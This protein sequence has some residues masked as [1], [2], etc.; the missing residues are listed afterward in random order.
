[1]YDRG[2]GVAQS[3]GAAIGWYTRAAEKGF[4]SAQFNLGLKYDIGRGTPEDDARAG[5]WYARA[6]E[7]GHV[8]SEYNLSVLDADK[9]ASVR[10]DDRF[11]E[12]WRELEAEEKYKN[13]AFKPDFQ[14]LVIRQGRASDRDMAQWY[15]IKREEEDRALKLVLAEKYVERSPILG[16]N[17]TPEAWFTPTAERGSPGAQFSLALIYDLGEGVAED[18]E[19]AARWYARAAQQGHV[20]ARYNLGLAYDEGAGVD[21]NDETAV[22]W[23]LQAAEQGDMKSQFNI[24]V[25]YSL[26]SGVE[27]SDETAFSWYKLAAE[28]GLA[29]AQYNLAVAYDTARGDIRRPKPRG[30]VVSP[31][32]GTG[33]C[34]R[35]VQS[36]R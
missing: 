26:G 19:T 21:E 27:K 2:E 7:Q 30:E 23:Y 11:T 16:K 33:R 15:A 32:R 14:A 25:K 12:E 3:Y 6:A 8:K 18:D 9:G 24:G 20:G 10:E 35:E 5:D 1:M 31:R 28:Q 36:R 22:S 34:E 17:T 4:A 29:Q 13:V